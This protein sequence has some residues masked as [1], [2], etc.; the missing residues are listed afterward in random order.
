[1][2]FFDFLKGAGDDKDDEKLEE[3]MDEL[4]KSNAIVRKMHRLNLPV[5]GL[6]IKYDDG[7]VTL[8]GPVADQATREKL[9]LAAGNTVGVSR[10]DDQLTVSGGQSGGGASFGQR[11]H[12]VEKGD[13]LSEIAQEKLGDA[14]R[15]KDIF[16]ANRPMLTDPDEIYPGQVLRI[17]A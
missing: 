14:S 7:T 8:S 13:T 10:V 16:E 17:P 5:Q 9:V 1:M 12:T 6:S 11:L 4:E 3:R 2:G 15:W